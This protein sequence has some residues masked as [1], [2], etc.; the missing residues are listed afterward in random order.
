[1]FQFEILLEL[2]L[3][4]LYNTYI[5]AYVDVISPGPGCSKRN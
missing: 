1:M 4:F 2:V 3:S 5:V